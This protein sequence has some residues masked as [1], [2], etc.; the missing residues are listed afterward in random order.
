MVA[1]RD[2][3][4]VAAL[5]NA[6]LRGNYFPGAESQPGPI[7]GVRQ[8]PRRALQ[9][10]RAKLKNKQLLCS[11]HSDGHQPK[12]CKR[13]KDGR[14]VAPVSGSSRV[15]RVAPPPITPTPGGGPGAGSGSSF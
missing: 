15:A 10:H 14:G 6:N 1:L 12:A 8:I 5:I 3:R 13:R 2:P 11:K 9:S 7:V 4:A